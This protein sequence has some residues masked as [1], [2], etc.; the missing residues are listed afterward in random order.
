LFLANAAACVAAIGALAYRPTRP[1]AALA[2]VVTSVLALAGLVVSYG[3]E[4]GLFGWP[5]AGF[6]T[7][8]VL[9]VI[10]ELAAVVLLSTGLAATTGLVQA[11]LGRAR[12]APGKEGTRDDVLSG[13]HELPWL[14]TGIEKTA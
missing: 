3:R 1:L 11:R 2:G 12:S 8:I 6:R 9:A 4:G 13:H 7:A 14:R 10:T 5:E